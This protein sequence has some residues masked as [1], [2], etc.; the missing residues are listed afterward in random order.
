MST[1]ALTLAHR[2][3]ARRGRSGSSAGFTLIE[4]IGVMLILVV[5][6]T[7]VTAL[8]IS[9][10][11][12]EI[13]LNRRFQAQ[14]EARTATDRMRQ[15]VHCASDLTFTSASSVTITLPATCPTSGGAVTTV[16]Y[17]T[18][19]VSTQRFELQR[20]GQRIADH[21]TAGGVFSFVSASTATLAKLHVDLPVNVFPAEAWKQ[22]RLETDIVLRN[23]VRA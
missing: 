4:L 20:N 19:M 14:T 10:S 17:A 21:L 3:H 22:W 16:T 23:T 8:F 5:I 1:R 12:A 7:A 2:L 13:D 11:R 15:E 9:G 18:S 6:L